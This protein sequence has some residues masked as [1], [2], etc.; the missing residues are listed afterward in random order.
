MSL[1][2]KIDGMGE[3]SGYDFHSINHIARESNIQLIDA[4]L[5]SNIMGIATHKGVYLDI[6]KIIN[7]VHGG[8][9]DWN[10]ALFIL[11]HELAH[12]KRIKKIGDDEHIKRLTCDDVKDF[13]DYV[14][15]EEIFADRWATRMFYRF[16]QELFPFNQTQ[17]LWNKH[18]RKEYASRIKYD[19]EF[20]KNNA[21]DYEK[22]IGNYVIDVR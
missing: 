12:A 9:F 6:D 4:E 13:C 11:Y 18:M 8:Q 3:Y 19:H 15:G 5:Y 2:D 14:I 10:K 21:E 16:N 17:G 7:A 22:V 1:E 20:I